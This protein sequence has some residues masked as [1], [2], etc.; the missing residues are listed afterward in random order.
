[1]GGALRSVWKVAKVLA[2]P[3]PQER[4]IDEYL[5]E[6]TGSSLQSAD[7]LIKAAKALGL[8]P[9]KVG[10]HKKELDDVFRARNKIIHE[11]D[12]NLERTSAR[13]N[14]NSRTRNKMEKWSNQLLKIG[15][16]MVSEVERKLRSVT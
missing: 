9:A 6:L 12:V 14:R 3:T 4:L 15:G 1:M 10:I 2:S 16:N 11:L 5:L 8:D 7:Q 13:R